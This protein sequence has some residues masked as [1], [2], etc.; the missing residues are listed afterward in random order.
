MYER[1][2]H[3]PFLSLLFV[4]LNSSALFTWEINLRPRDGYYPPTDTWTNTQI[5]YVHRPAG[6]HAH[7]QTQEHMFAGMEHKHAQYACARSS[8]L[9]TLIENWQTYSPTCH[10][11]TIYAY[12]LA[13]NV[14]PHFWMYACY[15]IITVIINCTPA[16]TV[17]IYIY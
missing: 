2:R 7:R 11:N 12:F 13:W 1:C 9:H 15:L 6:A 5:L 4:W 8:Y 17:K 3:A 16:S 14:R 10:I